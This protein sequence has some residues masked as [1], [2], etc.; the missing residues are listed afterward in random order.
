MIELGRRKGKQRKRDMPFFGETSDAL[1]PNPSFFRRI[2]IENREEHLA[3]FC[4]KIELSQKFE[5]KL[6]LALLTQRRL[7]GKKMVC[8]S[9]PGGDQIKVATIEFGE[10]TGII[11][12]KEFNV[13]EVNYTERRTN[14]TPFGTAYG[15][16]EETFNRSASFTK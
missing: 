2:D 15:L 8:D 5:H 4:V 12:R 9:Y 6:D 10:I 14:I 11:E 13:A 16:Y 1:K 3:V 7:A